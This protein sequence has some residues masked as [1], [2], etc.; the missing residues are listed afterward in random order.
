M[1][2]IL[3][4][5]K[6]HPAGLNVLEHA[7]TLGFTHDYIEEISEPSYAPL[8]DKAD[9]LVIRTQPMS[10]QTVARGAKLK[11]VSRH[12]VGYDAVDLPALNA[13]DIA[14]TIVGD[15]NSVSVAEHAM[16][17]MLAAAK[18]VVRANSAVHD[19]SKWGWRNTLEQQEVSGKRLLILGYG[20]IGRNL[21]RMAAGF[22]MQVRAYDPYLA[23]TAWP[24]GNVGCVTDLMDGLKWADFV[25]VHVPRADQ[26]L[27][28]AAEIDAL[29][30]GAIIVNTA[31][32]GVVDEAALAA[33]LRSGKVGA[34]G[35]DVFETEPP[36]TG[37]PLLDF[38][39]AVLSP[40]IAGLT[41]EAAERMAVMSARNVLDFFA[42]TIDPDLIVNG[43][44]ITAACVRQTG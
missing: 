30:P 38:D 4:A 5:G 40:H 22:E 3:V 32:G 12:G 21:A 33:G 7:R 2:H 25:S 27:I 14:L 23:R 15:V 11:V 42:G 18:R 39:Q 24:D 26:P 36:T 29:K 10:A 37:S 35:F 44:S 19:A 31:R 1:P 16:M 34:I 6:L 17:Q 41:F 13:P 20:R 43:A 9:A 28:G 8:I